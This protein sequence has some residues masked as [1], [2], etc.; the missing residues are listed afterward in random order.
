RGTVDSWS[1]RAAAYGAA[2]SAPG[3]TQ[4]INEIRVET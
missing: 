3:V 2:A 4:V 1:E